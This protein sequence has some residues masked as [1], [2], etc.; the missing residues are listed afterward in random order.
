[1]EL[2]TLKELELPIGAFIGN[3][4]GNHLVVDLKELREEAIK[5]VKTFGL[6]LTLYDWMRFFN[7][8]DEDLNGN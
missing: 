4:S 8:T 6:N 3:E 5:W 7:I 2:K 1:M